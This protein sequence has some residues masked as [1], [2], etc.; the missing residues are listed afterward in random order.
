MEEWIRCLSRSLFWF[1]YANF[2]ASSDVVVVVVIIDRLPSLLHCYPDVADGGD[3]ASCHSVGTCSYYCTF[4]KRETGGETGLQ[5][6]RIEEAYGCAMDGAVDHFDVQPRSPRS[7]PGTRHRP[8]FCP[9]RAQEILQDG[10]SLLTTWN[11]CSKTSIS[12][13]IS[14]TTSS[15]GYFS[16]PSV[17]CTL[18]N[19]RH[20]RRLACADGG[21]TS[22]AMFD[23]HTCGPQKVHCSGETTTALALVII[24]KSGICP[25]SHSYY[26]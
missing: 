19:I 12:H 21:M 13:D 20:R 18:Q 15:H 6:T 14:P 26:H 3:I 23:M 25:P 1:I 8:G 2:S 10:G 24:A 4:D 11:R 9:L 7:V 16:L 5:G 22:P 17:S